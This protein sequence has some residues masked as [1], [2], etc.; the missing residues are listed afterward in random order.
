MA[1]VAP[2]A[3][4]ASGPDTAGDEV[5]ELALDKRRQAVAAGVF[6]S[7][8][9][10]RGEMLADDLVEHGMIGVAQAVRAHRSERRACGGRRRLRMHRPRS[11][12][13]AG[14][15][16]TRCAAAA[17][18]VPRGHGSVIGHARRE[19]EATSSGLP[20]PSRSAV[21]SPKAS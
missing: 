15:G 5:A 14:T 3:S 8:A 13:F 17:S 7:G 18:R 16:R 6:G 19:R 9:E 20:P 11:A 2:K 4:E 21:L 10:E 1:R 12:A